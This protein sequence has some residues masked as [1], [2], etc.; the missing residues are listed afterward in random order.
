VRVAYDDGAKA[1]KLTIMGKPKF[2]IG[3]Q[4]LVRVQ[5]G[6][7]DVFAILPGGRGIVR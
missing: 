5:A 7:D 4:L 6:G 1:V 3:G 2:A